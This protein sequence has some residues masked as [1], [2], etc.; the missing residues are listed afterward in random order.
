LLLVY[1]VELPVDPQQ[2]TKLTVMIELRIPETRIWRAM[3]GLDR[4]LLI[5]AGQISTPTDEADDE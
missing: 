5:V 4:L 3:N 1:G 2:L